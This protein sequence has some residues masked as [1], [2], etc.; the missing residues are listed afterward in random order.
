ME[1]AWGS[2]SGGMDKE[3]AVEIYNGIL[4]GQKNGALPPATARWT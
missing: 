4:F 3:E 2:T 1:A